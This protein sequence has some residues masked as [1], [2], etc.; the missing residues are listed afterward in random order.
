[1]EVASTNQG[2]IPP[3]RQSSEE[4]ID[5]TRGN[6]EGISRAT[7]DI[8]EIRAPQEP[9]GVRMPRQGNE[10]GETRGSRADRVEVSEEAHRMLAQEGKKVSSA[11]EKRARH[12]S[13]LKHSY[14][15]G[16]LNSP[17]RVQRA[18]IEMLRST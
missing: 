16:T 18:A 2:P 7:E 17:E 6:R 15:G 12:L 4:R 1:M 13:E 10:S 9:Y 5:L 11:D 14:E 3:R 8:S